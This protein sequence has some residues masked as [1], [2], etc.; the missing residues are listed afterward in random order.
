MKKHVLASALVLATAFTAAPAFAQGSPQVVQITRVE[1]KTVDAGFRASKVIG[2]TVYNDAND[3]IGT[4]DDILITR[5]GKEPYA[6]LSVGGFLGMGTKLVVVRYD[7]LKFGKDKTILP[8]G[9][10]DGLKALPEFKYA[11]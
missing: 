11:N 6:V 7:S 9:T 3:S 1:L 2:S 10:K 4:I 5:D 8:G